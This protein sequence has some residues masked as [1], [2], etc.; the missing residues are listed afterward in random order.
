MLVLMAPILPLYRRYIVPVA[1]QHDQILEVRLND[2]WVT[3]TLKFANLQF[4]LTLDKYTFLCYD[5]YHN[6]PLQS[7]LRQSNLRVR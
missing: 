7:P 5:N 2:S 1:P 6:P 4:K 3:N